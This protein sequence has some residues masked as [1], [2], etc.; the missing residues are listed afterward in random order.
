MTWEDLASGPFLV[1]TW[2]SGPWAY[3]V[4]RARLAA[5]AGRVEVRQHHV[6]REALMALVGLGL[7]ATVV[8]ESAAGASYPGVVF[9]PLTDADA[10]VPATALWLE[11]NDN[12][13]RH[14]L[15]AMLRDAASRSDTMPQRSVA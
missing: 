13:V 14:R 4:L 3:N 12:P 11:E 10:V 7:G 6:S 1:R 8:T 5:W 15:V 9:Q 2:E